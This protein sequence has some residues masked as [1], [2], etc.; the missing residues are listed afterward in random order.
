MKWALGND[1]LK[2]L[3]KESLCEIGITVLGDIIRILK[4]AK[5]EVKVV[6][7]MKGAIKK[8]VLI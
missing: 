6:E 8:E 7:V 5:T 4:H 1:T 2:Y 3:D